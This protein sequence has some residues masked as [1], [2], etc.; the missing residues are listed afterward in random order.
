[1]N[2]EKSRALTPL[3]RDF[4]ERFFSRNQNFFLADLKVERIP[5]YVLEPLTVPELDQFIR[6][7]QQTMAALAFSKS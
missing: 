7:L 1:M 4:L 5:E 2:W 6:K 3:K